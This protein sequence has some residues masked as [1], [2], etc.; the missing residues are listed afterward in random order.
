M[1]FS[2]R[3]NFNAKGREETEAFFTDSLAAWKDSVSGSSASNPR[4]LQSCWVQP[5]AVTAK[6][7]PFPVAHLR[8]ISSDTC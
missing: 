8:P 2:G 7:H 5:T 3:P 6:V 1:A 4:V